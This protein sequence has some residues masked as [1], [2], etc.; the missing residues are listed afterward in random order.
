MNEIMNVNEV[1]TMSS[2]EI[3]ELTGKAHKNVLRKIDR[4]V[5]MGFDGA[6]EISYRGY[7]NQRMREFIIDKHSP[8]YQE[9]VS[10]T[11]GV[12]GFL[13][14]REK[15]AL[16]TVEQLQG[17]KLIRQYQVLGGRYRIDGYDPVNNIAYEIDEEQHFT[18]RHQEAD[19]KRE[20]EIKTE[21][22]CKFVRIRV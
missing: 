5:S 22:G 9:I 10:K 21:L 19:R 2:R 16:T 18:S 3:A 20:K 13:G 14:I 8:V 15:T 11:L 17:V 7:N 6:T 12:V 4:L 1:Q